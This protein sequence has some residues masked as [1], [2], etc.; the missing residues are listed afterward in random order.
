MWRNYFQFTYKRL[1]EE[2]KILESKD[3]EYRCMNTGLL[4]SDSIWEEEISG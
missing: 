3:G 4:E 2:G 1:S